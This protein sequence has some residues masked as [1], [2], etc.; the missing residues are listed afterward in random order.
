MES[1][2]KA[3]YEDYEALKQQA[4]ELHQGQVAKIKQDVAEESKSIIE[5]ALASAEKVLAEERS[6]FESQRREWAAIRSRMEKEHQELVEQTSAQNEQLQI[7]VDSLSEEL[8][9]VRKQMP[10]SSANPP[11]ATEPKPA[12]KETKDPIVDLRSFTQSRVQGLLRSQQSGEDFKGLQQPQP[13]NTANLE[14]R[15]PTERFQSPA[16][17]VRSKPDGETQR[18]PNSSKP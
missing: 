2:L 4:E 11:P 5:S 18:L 16:P 7:K 13:I 15:E 1:H 12:L 10:S 8:L 6:R 17:S 14:E 3:A 9:A